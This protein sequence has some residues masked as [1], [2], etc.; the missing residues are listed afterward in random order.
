MT[1][2][3][4]HCRRDGLPD[5]FADA[6]IRDGD[7]LAAAVRYDFGA[8]VATLPADYRT[9]SLSLYVERLQDWVR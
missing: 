2:C 8:L 6:G 9:E 3:W 5:L 7:L 1:V 4:L